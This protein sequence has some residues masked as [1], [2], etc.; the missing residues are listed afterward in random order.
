MKYVNKKHAHYPHLSYTC[1][2][3]ITLRTI[4]YNTFNIEGWRDRK[5]KQIIDPGTYVISK[6]YSQL[7][8][9]KVNNGNQL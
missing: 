1:I 5:L 3:G 9:P 8:I 6:G 2:P 7:E 4:E